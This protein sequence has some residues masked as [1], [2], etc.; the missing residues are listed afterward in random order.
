[1]NARLL[2]LLGAAAAAL[3]HKTSAV[4]TC[5]VLV[6]SEITSTLADPI[7]KI[8][9]TPSSSTDIDDTPSSS[10]T[11]GSGADSPDAN[12]SQNEE[13]GSTFSDVSTSAGS[14]DNAPTDT[15]T[16]TNKDSKD[17][18]D[19]SSP[20]ETTD[21]TT[22]SATPETSS[23][24]PETP[25]S[26]SDTPSS[27]SDTPS[28]KSDTPASTPDTP[29]TIQTPTSS[30]KVSTPIT[31]SVL[32]TTPTTE[33]TSPPSA[34]ATAPVTAPA[35]TTTASVTAPT[36]SKSLE[37]AAV[38]TVSPPSTDRKLQ[39]TTITPTAIQ[40][41]TETI[42]ATGTAATT[43]AIPVV[44]TTGTTGTPTTGTP[45]TGT[46]TTGTPTTGTPTTGTPTSGT[47]TT[48]TS[49]T[50]TPTTGTP[51]TGTPTTGT[52]TT[53]TPTTGTP[54][55]GTTTTGTTTTGTT[56]EGLA[57]TDTTAEN[58][59]LASD[60]SGSP[61]SK[62]SSL[63]CDSA[64]YLKWDTLG[65]KCGGLGID[66]ASAVSASSCVIYS[67]SVGSTSGSTCVSICSFPTCKDNAWVY[68]AENGI[69]SSVYKGLSIKAFLPSDVIAA[70]ENRSSKVSTV[71]SNSTIS[72]SEQCTY[73]S[74]DSFSSCS[75]SAMLVD[76]SS[77]GSEADA[78]KKELR[79]QDEE[80]GVITK[81]RTTTAGTVVAATSKSV[82]GVTVVVTGIAAIAS[83][84][85]GGVSSAGAS[86]AA[87]GSTMAITT[88]ELCQFGVMINQ[89]QLDGKSSAVT[90]LGKAM[91]PMAFLFLP[92][93]K[94]NETK[95]DSLGSGNLSGDPAG[96]R[97]SS[98]SE[99]GSSST[100]QLN[101]IEKYSR[102]L[103]V[104]EDMLFI[105]TLAGVFCMMACVVGLFGIGYLLSGLMMPREQYLANFFDKMI[106]LEVL[107][108]VLSQY[109][110]GVTA[111]FQIYYS[112]KYESIMDPK[113]LLAIAAIIFLAA[114]ILVYGYIVIKKHEADI[115][116]VGTVQHMKKTVNMRYGP[117]YEEYKF[118][119]RYFFA[120]KMMLALT[121]GVVTGC[122]SMSGKAQIAIILALNVAF[123]FY[124]E[125][126]SPHHSKFVQTTT[127]FVSIMKIAVLVLTFFLVTAATSDGFPTSLQNGISLA[128]VGLN[129][130]VLALLMI[131][132]LYSFW[133][134][135]K[136]QRNAAYDQEEQ[137]AQDYFKDET[138]A[139]HKDH[140]LSNAQQPSGPPVLHSQTQNLNNNH[141][142]YVQGNADVDYNSADEIRLR[143][144][145]HENNDRQQTYDASGHAAAN[146]YITEDQ[147][148]YGQRRND[149]V[150][151]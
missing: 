48:E 57:Q 12:D 31:D 104:Q 149:V 49:T 13:V 122:A 136:L 1:M 93:G 125:I 130:F 35:L 17:S 36:I 39:V 86:F 99:N 81:D 11:S 52:P 111:T 64:F 26:K 91:A 92:F 129:L 42:G 144:A 8:I 78:V 141:S 67:G 88:V 54:T 109:T 53:G 46:P 27:K 72:N 43:T 32:N 112:T 9:L 150:E 89:L 73:S 50:G 45:T 148:V 120:A 66:V 100:S 56:P 22:P 103:N 94:L 115:A 33:S 24:T 145:T 4:T 60:T 41:T 95:S 51:T 123:F 137:T 34:P 85:V 40:P 7:T 15:T 131:R 3:A 119:N 126:Q 87:A 96:R 58:S 19:V 138:P 146:H 147:N 134:K 38:S 84:A 110:V 71:L 118:K 117:L 121:T 128:I 63:L 75:C 98:T 44:G 140:V 135:L 108:A 97:L 127:S 102:Q 114:G 106:G 25:S 37:T 20:P 105:V 59:S 5:P 143:S 10:L 69:S 113:C 30:T 77:S 68:G 101:G 6:Q 76:I 80:E 151:L 70:M 61:T 14:N 18:A 47:P 28:S 142:P 55:T 133:Q 83:A 107:V 21:N 65:L 82:A 116:D 132:S 2:A 62:T 90:H 29:A 124:L 74:E 16:T 23:A 139:G 79:Q